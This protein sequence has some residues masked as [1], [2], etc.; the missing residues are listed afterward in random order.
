MMKKKTMK[1]GFL[2]IGNDPYDGQPFTLGK[3]ETLKKAIADYQFAL[4]SAD[5]EYHK[6]ANLRIV[7]L[8]ERPIDP[9]LYKEVQGENDEV[10]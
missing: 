5:A 1:H 6:R 10:F 9:A 8:V 4:R 7:E 2:V 3:Q